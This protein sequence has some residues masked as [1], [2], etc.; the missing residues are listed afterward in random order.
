MAYWAERNANMGK[1]KLNVS[2][3]RYIRKHIEMTAQQ[4]AFKYG[5]SRQTIINVRQ[6][7]FYREVL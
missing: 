7:K 6:G 2:Q 4:L 5:V 3:V 1:R